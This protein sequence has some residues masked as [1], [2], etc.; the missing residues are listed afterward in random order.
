[1]TTDSHGDRAL[2]DPETVRAQRRTVHIWTIVVVA[3]LVF[4]ALTYL[5]AV[6]TVT[7]Q[8]IENAA[9]RGADQ[10]DPAD[11]QQAD[12]ALARITV[13]S[14]AVGTAAVCAVGLLRRQ[15]VLAFA[16]G[17]IVVGGQVVTQSLKRFVLPR[18]ELVDVT[19]AY[20]HNSLPSGHTTIAMTVLV[21]TMIVV[22]YRFRGVAMFVVL[23]WAVGIGAYTIVA[24]WHRLSDTL[25]ADAVALA[26]GATV[27]LVLTRTGH[28]RVVPV[29]GRRRYLRSVFVFVVA[30]VG[31]VSAAVGAL[32]IMLTWNRPPIDEVSEYNFFLGAHSLASAGSIAAAL[33]FWWS[34]HRVELRGRSRD[35]M[36]RTDPSITV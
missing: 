17:S 28:L 12:D 21:A 27:C 8:T 20:A 24:K 23:T 9:L 13:L 16:A 33:V 26:V 34:L 30:F 14:L 36:T 25:A 5:A 6:W 10:V 2:E 18:P 15:P 3:A 22:P 19:A 29:D 4:G 31:A 35:R 32:L 1:M 11:L 7:G